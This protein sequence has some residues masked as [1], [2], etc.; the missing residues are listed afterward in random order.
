MKKEMNTATWSTW[1]TSVVIM[2]LFLQLVGC[3]G[4][5]SDPA[6]VS[7]QDAVKAKLTAATKW[8]LQTAQVDGVDKTSTYSGLSV[9]F[10]STSYTTTNG[11]GLWPASGT[12]SFV[13]TDGKSIKRN[14]GTEMA[15]EVTDTSL[16]LSFSW[17][18]ATVGG[19]RVESIA[20]QHVLSFTK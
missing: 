14:D 6:P 20:G 2:T 1:V 3:G 19:G 15:V 13:D 11:K 16:K 4:K 5:G 18:K 7:A 17:T 10:A 12:W 8:N 9:T